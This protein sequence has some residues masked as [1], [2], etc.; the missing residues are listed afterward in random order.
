MVPEFSGARITLLGAQVSAYSRANA[1]AGLALGF[2]GA[3]LKLCVGVNS[4]FRLTL[5]SVML[6][7]GEV[8][9]ELKGGLRLHTSLPTVSEMVGRP[10]F[11]LEMSAAEERCGVITFRRGTRSCACR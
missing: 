6:G 3:G 11:P 5:M 8:A 9:C 4:G 2:L 7:K 1:C 10:M